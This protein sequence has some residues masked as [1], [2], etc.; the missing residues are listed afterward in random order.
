MGLSVAFASCLVLCCSLYYPYDRD[1]LF[2]ERCVL[3]YQEMCGLLQFEQVEF[4]NASNLGDSCI[5]RN[6]HGL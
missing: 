4:G 2:L 6:N 5:F 3:Q 1:G